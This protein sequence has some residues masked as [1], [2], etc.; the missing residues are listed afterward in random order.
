[1]SEEKQNKSKSKRKPPEVKNKPSSRSGLVTLI[2]M[3]LVF[4]ALQFFASNERKGSQNITQLEFR[5]AV[6]QGLV[7]KVERVR[8]TDSDETYL[9]GAM[10]PS[11]PNAKARPFKVVLVPRENEELMQ[12][13]TKHNLD[14]PIKE[15]EPVIGPILMQMLIVFVPF[16]LIYW[17]FFRRMGAGGGQNPFSMGKSKAKLL[18]EDNKGK[19][20]ITFKDVAGVDEARE[21]VQEIIEFLK[22][23]QKFKKLGGRIPK[24]VLLVGPPG[25]GKTLLAKAISGEAE[26]PFFSIS[27]SDFEEMFVG[28]GAS[29]VRDLFRQA[30]EE[31]MKRIPAL[32]V[33]Q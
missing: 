15:K 7:S 13:M 19:N 17:F 12:F 6:Q 30:K 2:V 18:N 32:K 26:V 23:P 31:N 10:K 16:A 14:C 33:R 22:G 1:M 25:T 29:R 20:R 21:E 11:S 4:I 8:E 24:G 9:V 5:K 27:G 3:G 28:V